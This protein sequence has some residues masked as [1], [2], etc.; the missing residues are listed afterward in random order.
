[1]IDDRYLEVTES[2]R[3]VRIENNV[4]VEPARVAVN[5]G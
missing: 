4:G 3:R 5:D 1:M 2:H